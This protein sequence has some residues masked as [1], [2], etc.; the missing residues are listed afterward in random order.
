MMV[1]WVVICVLHLAVALDNQST[2]HAPAT[3]WKQDDFW[4]SFWVGPQVNVVCIQRPIISKHRRNQVRLT[5]ATP[6]TR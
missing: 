3:G 2:A 1:Q 5:T 4:L 6:S